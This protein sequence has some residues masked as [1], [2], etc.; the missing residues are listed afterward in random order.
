MYT[1]WCRW[2]AAWTARCLLVSCHE[3]VSVWRFTFR[4]ES[5][6]CCLLCG[7]CHNARDVNV[8]LCSSVQHCLLLDILCF[9]SPQKWYG[10]QLTWTSVSC[11]VSDFIYTKFHLNTHTY[12][13]TYYFAPFFLP[14]RLLRSLIIQINGKYVL[15]SDLNL[16]SPNLCLY[17]LS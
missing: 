3:G 9:R 8:K 10:Y 1:A 17:L 11:W 16:I 15:I 13:H 12:T 14:K 5:T 6:T 7:I 4:T 2:L